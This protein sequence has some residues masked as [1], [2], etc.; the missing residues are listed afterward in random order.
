MEPIGYHQHS[1]ENSK[2]QEITS[3]RETIVASETYNSSSERIQQEST[4]RHNMCNGP[5]PEIWDIVKITS[6]GL[7]LLSECC[8]RGAK[9]KEDL[10]DQ[11]QGPETGYTDRPIIPGSVWGSEGRRKAMLRTHHESSKV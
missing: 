4:E 3:N 11:N 10:A 6:R 7:A 9:E 8:G 2:K 1:F 5:E